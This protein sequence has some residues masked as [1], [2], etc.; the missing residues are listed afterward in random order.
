M[1]AQN[2]NELNE[3]NQR[4]NICLILAVD[5]HHPQRMILKDKVTPWTYLHEFENTKPHQY[6]PMK[7]KCAQKT[8]PDLLCHSLFRPFMIPTGWTLL[9]LM[10]STPPTVAWKHNL[11]HYGTDWWHLQTLPKRRNLFKWGDSY[12]VVSSP[13]KVLQ[14]TALL[15]MSQQTAKSLLILPNTLLWA[16]QLLQ[17]H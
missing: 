1:S 7:Q 14:F 13:C 2:K 17:G 5:I 4:L 3:T 8:F 12:S 11:L 6:P 9:I 16:Q 10:I 15:I